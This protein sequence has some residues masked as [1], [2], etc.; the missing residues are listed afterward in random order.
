MKQLILLLMCAVLTGPLLGQSDSLE[1]K[2]IRL[3]EVS[4]SEEMFVSSAMN[5]IQL[6]QQSAAYADIP[7]TWWSTFMDRLRTEGFKSIEPELVKIYMANYTEEE[8]DFLIDYHRN[9][10][11]QSIMAKM[12]VVQQQSMQVGQAWGQQIAQEIVERLNSDSEG[13]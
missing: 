12:P 8:V 11:A 13:N 3:I 10:L 2:V 1:A 9:P 6:Q 4:G 7:D 5:M